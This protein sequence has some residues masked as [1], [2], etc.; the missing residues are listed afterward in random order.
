M[1]RLTI[2]ARSCAAIASI[3]CSVAA[4]AYHCCSCSLLPMST[5]PPLPASCW[6]WQ[7][8]STPSAHAS[9]AWM[10][11]IGACNSSIGFTPRWELSPL[12]LGTRSGKRTA[13]ACR[14]LGHPRNWANAARLN[15]S[16]AASFSSSVCNGHLTLAGQPSSGKSP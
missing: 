3:S 6:N 8:A 9:S 10:P 12:F 15:A 5:M 16:L 4:L 7:S 11:R 13:R 1:P 2:R 14:P